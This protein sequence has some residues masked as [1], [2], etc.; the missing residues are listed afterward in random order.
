MQ[1]SGKYLIHAKI[2]ADGVVERS[3]VV[4][5]IFGQTEG[6]LGDE[7]DLRY[8]QRASKVGR[9]DVEIES[10]EGQSVGTVT[11]GT[12]L[13]KVETAT[14]AAALETIT[15]VGPCEASVRVT[16]IEDVRAAKRREVVERAHELLLEAFDGA[17][18]GEELIDEVRRR[19]RVEDITEYEGLPAGPN[20]PNSDAVIIVEGRADVLRLLEAGIKN[21][22]AVEGT[23]IPSAIKQLM[24]NRTVT[25][26]FDGDRGGELLF[27]E[28]TQVGE[29]DYVAVAPENTSVEDLSRREVLTA[30]REKVPYSEFEADGSVTLDT[31]VHSDGSSTES[32]GDEP[33]D[34]HS[35][36]RTNGT[37]TPT[38]RKDDRTANLATPR[39]VQDHVTAVITEE[40]GTV[41]LLDADDEVVASGDA[42]EAFD[43]LDAAETAPTTVILDGPI[44]QRLLD[45]AAQRGVH[46]V[47]GAS[48]GDIT[49]QPTTV[50]CRTVAKS[51]AAHPPQ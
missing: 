10:E 40:T 33:S 6:L 16:N 23:D 17:L 30:L 9:L 20:V 13:D 29:V 26:F 25:V 27:R 45:L 4:G 15:R 47:V 24:S 46:E 12:T 48:Q 31:D 37:A 35:E 2:R 18:T 21:A 44:T 19:A 8:L 49:K 3:D 42:D 1:H 11:I 38:E 7:L 14:I 51:R 34:E 22:I 50:R 32:D 5:A 43:L 28:L 36:E 39:S 41:R